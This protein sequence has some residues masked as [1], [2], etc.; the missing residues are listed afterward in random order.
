[1]HPLEDLDHR[2]STHGIQIETIRQ[3]QH[4]TRTWIP[5]EFRREGKAHPFPRQ[6]ASD[7]LL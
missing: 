1:M 4:V 5:I 6:V 2:I 3:V 7:L